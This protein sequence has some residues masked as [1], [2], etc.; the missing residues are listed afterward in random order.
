[1]SIVT[2]KKKTQVQYNNMSVGCKNGF[3]LNGTYRSQGYVGQTMLSRSLPSTLMKGNVTKGHGGCCG[4]YPQNG[5]IQ[6]A[7]TSL[8]DSTVIKSSVLNTSGMIKTKYRWI[9]RPQP[10]SSTKVDSFHNSNPQSDYISNLSVN[11]INKIDLSYSL[12]NPLCFEK[13][14]IN[15][16][17]KAFPRININPQI[18]QTRNPGNIVKT[19]ITGPENNNPLMGISGRSYINKC[20]TQQEYID[21]ID[22]QCINNNINISSNCSNI[23]KNNIN[24]TP[25]IG[26]IIS[27]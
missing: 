7:V 26:G 11:T 20:Y 14:C 10:Y 5:I 8:N 23:L 13:I 9:W 16:P 2:L 27:F 15:L 25:L 4:K 19:N 12:Y 18:I 17:R 24:N 21:K 3:S 1:M 6:S 22:T